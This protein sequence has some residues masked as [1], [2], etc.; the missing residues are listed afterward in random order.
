MLWSRDAKL[1][2]S[3]RSGIQPNFWEGEDREGLEGKKTLG[4]CLESYGFAPC[5]CVGT[6][7]LQR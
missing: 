7:S 3:G 4:L 6:P 5:K 2:G 1:L